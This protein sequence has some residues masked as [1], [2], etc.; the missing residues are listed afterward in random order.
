M[1]LCP[2]LYSLLILSHRLYFHQGRLKSSIRSS[3]KYTWIYKLPGLGRAGQGGTS[4]E[5]LVLNLNGLDLTVFTFTRHFKCLLSLCKF[6]NMV[7]DSPFSRTSGEAKVGWEVSDVLDWKD[8]FEWGGERR[9]GIFPFLNFLCQFCNKDFADDEKWK[10]KNKPVT[11]KEI[12][13]QLFY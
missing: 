10:I 8:N 6:G 7:N 3:P 11:F 1:S 13:G 2:K 5:Q 9:W 4:P 12:A